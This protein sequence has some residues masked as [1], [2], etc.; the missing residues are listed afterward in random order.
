MFMA[1]SYAFDPAET[2]ALMKLN[3]RCPVTEESMKREKAIAARNGTS[4]SLSERISSFFE[5][6]D[7]E[8]L[9]DGGLLSWSY[10]EAGT[11]ESVGCLVCYF[12]AMWYAYSIAP[13]DLVNYAQT[14]GT[15]PIL[16]ANGK[17]LVFYI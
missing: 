14:W 12:F 17:L 4:Q 2:K 13:V 9:V 3:P 8:V 15:V 1:L 10:I 5:K 7:G 11:I 16:L 6:K